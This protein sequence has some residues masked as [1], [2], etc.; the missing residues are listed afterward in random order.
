MD[1][2]LSWK[3]H[4]SELTEKLSRSS[5]IFFI[6]RH[7]PQNILKN[8]YFPIF[9]SFL[10]YGLSTWC[11]SYDTYLEALFLLQKKVLW[12]ISFQSFSSPSTPIFFSQ[13]VLKLNDMIQHNTLQFV[14]KSLNNLLP[15]HSLNYFQLSSTVHTHETGQAIGVTLFN[16]SDLFWC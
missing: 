15:S 8:L 14:Y 1:E 13:K 3:F 12:A 2:H 16:L 11:L 4:I 5:G 6:V 10:S 9:S 7:L